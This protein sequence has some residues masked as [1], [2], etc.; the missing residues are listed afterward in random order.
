MSKKPQFA[1]NFQEY[2]K[3]IRAR[4]LTGDYTELSLR[5]PLENFVRSLNKDYGLIQ[6]PKRTRNL[7][8]PDFKAFNGIKK[9]GYIETKDLNRNLDEELKSDQIEKYRKSID[10][11]ILTNYFRFILLKH[12]KILFDFNLFNLSDLDDSKFIVQD[13]NIEKYLSLISVFFGYNLTTLKTPEELSFELS[14]RAKLLKDLAKEQL[15]EDILKA[16]D[17]QPA[18]SIYDFYVGAKELIHDISVDDCADAYAQTIAYGLFLARM[19][20]TLNLDRNNAASFIPRSIGVIKK[21]FLNISGDAVPSSVSWIIDEIVEIMNASDMNNIISTIDARGKTDRDPFTFFYEDFLSAFDPEKKKHLGVYYTPRPVVHFIVNSIDLILQNDF[22]KSGGFTEDDVT[23]LDP[24]VGTG[25]FLWLIY[26]LTLVKLKNSGMSGLI[27][28][29]IENH[30]LKDFYGIEILITP[31]IIAHLKLS[32]VLKKWFYEV[33]DT[34]RSQVYL[35]NTLE[36]FVSHGLMAFMR[37]ISEESR[38]ANELKLKRRVLVITGNPPYHGMSA[39]KGEWIRNLLKNGYVLKSG[40][41]DFGYSS[42]DGHPLG[43]KNPKWLQD[44]YV[45]FIRFAQWKMDVAGEGIIGF[46]TNHGY[47]DNPT[48]RGMRQSLLKSFDAIYVLNLHGSVLRNKKRANM[49][50]DENVFDIRLA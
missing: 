34:E 30:I 10:N 13:R 47:L 18:S 1:T 26:T 19:N 15:N 29:K 46:I 33:K 28:K 11:I 4:Y 31:Y 41:E 2:F 16:K 44:D 38:I 14:K 25:T 24:A 7:G 36:P 6:E 23:V 9:I 39:N 17:N 3:E 5:T 20:S 40:I 27:R 22:G 8:A 37:E 32:M 21:I 48:F 12:D 50:K 49:E 43:E 45:K 42:V 35:A